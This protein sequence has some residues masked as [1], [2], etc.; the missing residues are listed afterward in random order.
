[1]RREARSGRGAYRDRDFRREDAGEEGMQRAA[2][3]AEVATTAV[4]MMRCA[5][6]AVVMMMVCTVRRRGVELHR[7]VGAWR[8]HDAS[9]LRDQEQ[10]RKQTGKQ[11]QGP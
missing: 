9:Q 8:R 1:M 2:V 10:G 5:S 3:A 6:I 7:L 11:M 4:V